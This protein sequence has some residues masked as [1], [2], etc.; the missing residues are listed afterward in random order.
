MSKPVS[1]LVTSM[2][3][4]SPRVFVC[5]NEN[6]LGFFEGQ[7]DCA[8]LEEDIVFFDHSMDRLREETKPEFSR[9]LGRYLEKKHAEKPLTIV[10]WNRKLF[11]N[12]MLEFNKSELKGT[13]DIETLFKKGFF[14]SKEEFVNFEEEHGE[15][16]E[17]Y[18]KGKQVKAACGDQEEACAEVEGKAEDS[19]FIAQEYANVWSPQSK[20]KATHKISI[21]KNLKNVFKNLKSSK[22]DESRCK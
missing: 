17:E 4:F 11:R 8:D 16:L 22:C 7:I 12:I 3:R 5:K 21:C 2:Q 6:D 14:T 18:F 19:L 10:N 15:S 13:D 1:P 20:L 9:I